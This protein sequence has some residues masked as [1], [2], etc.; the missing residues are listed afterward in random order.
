METPQFDLISIKR[1]PPEEAIIRLNIYIVS[2][3][4]DEE[5]LTIRGQRLWSMGRRREAVNDFLAAINI[6]P[7]SRAKMLLDYYNSIL[8]YYNK[9]LY[10]P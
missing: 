4:A 9:D 2:N 8:D 10:N 1:L 5:A 7:Q 6:N 3:P